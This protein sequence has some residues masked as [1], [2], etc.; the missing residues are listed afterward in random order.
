MAIE[1]TAKSPPYICNLLF[2]AISTKLSVDC[3]INGEIPKPSTGKMILAFGIIY[4]FFILSILFFP[5][6]NISTQIAETP[7]AIIVANAAPFT[8]ILKPNIKIGSSIM[9]IKAPIATVIIPVVANP[10]VFIKVFI[11]IEI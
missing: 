10:W 3:I 9:F 1:P 5:K 6:R 8:P 4:F 7:C 2:K 11:P